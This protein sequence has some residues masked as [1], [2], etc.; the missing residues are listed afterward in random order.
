[1]DQKQITD[2]LTALKED[3]KTTEKTTEKYRCNICKKV[4]KR[5]PV[6]EDET[7]E[8]HERLRKRVLVEE[9]DLLCDDCWQRVM[10]KV[11][12][13]I[14]LRNSVQNQNSAMQKD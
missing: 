12:D 1:M 11:L 2:I 7:L 5:P 4:F 8:L 3:C 14:L 9:R 6:K 10:K 13:G